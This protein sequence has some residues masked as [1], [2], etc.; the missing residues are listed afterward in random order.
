MKHSHGQVIC[1]R[2]LATSIVQLF[3]VGHPVRPDKTLLCRVKQTGKSAA[4]VEFAEELCLQV[5]SAYV[6]T[7]TS[8]NHL[9]YTLEQ[10]VC[11]ASQ[12]MALTWRA[13]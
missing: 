6:K 4:K 8:T 9:N 1:R 3:A 2:S 12:L 11:S 10:L 13:T 7:N 5:L